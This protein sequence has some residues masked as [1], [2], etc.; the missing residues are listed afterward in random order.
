[1]VDLLEIVLVIITLFSALFVAI[2][3]GLKQTTG[4]RG[5]EETRRR[6]ERIDTKL[7][8]DSEKELSE[9]I[10]CEEWKDV[11]ER[12]EIVQELGHHCFVTQTLSADLLD[13]SE[14]YVKNAI[15]NLIIATLLLFVTVFFIANYYSSS[16]LAFAGVAYLILPILFYYQMAQSIG[17]VAYLRREFILLDENPNLPYAVTL[18]EKLVDKKFI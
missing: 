9:A 14:K 11:K 3:E 18:W 8:G 10:E 2:T 16:Q 1:M 13:S 15:R 5:S 6:K 12:K 7:M 4:Y 17:K